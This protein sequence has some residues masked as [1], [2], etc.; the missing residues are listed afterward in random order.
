M[1]TDD[2]IFCILIVNNEYHLKV[3]YV[4]KH[5][6]DA[7]LRPENDEKSFQKKNCMHACVI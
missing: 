4:W 1:S 6:M 3:I 7:C 5:C 2:W